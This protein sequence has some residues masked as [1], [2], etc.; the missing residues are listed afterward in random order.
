M[1]RRPLHEVMQWPAWTLGAY[2]EYLRKEP[3][4]DEKLEYMVAYA[5]A[6]YVNSNRARGT[7]AKPITDFMLFRNAWSV[8][9]EGDDQPETDLLTVA[10]QMGAVIR[11]R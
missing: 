8:V 5:I 1:I 11:P 4:P 9:E 7:E 3:A 10:R 6:T 2:A